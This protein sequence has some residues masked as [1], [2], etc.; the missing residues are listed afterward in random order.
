MQRADYRKLAPEGLRA[1][2]QLETYI[3]NSSIEHSLLELVK[4]RVSQING[5]AYCLDMHTT[6]ARKAGETEQRLYVLSAFREA[7]FFTDREKAALTWAEILTTIADKHPS[8]EDY[9]AVSKHFSDKEIVDL[10]FIIV[11]INGWN[12][13][14]IGFGIKPPAY[15][16]GEA[17]PAD[18]DR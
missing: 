9:A 17:S 4:T 8:D 18:G 13:M 16:D 5:C 3:Q 12:R 11:A 2:V 15:P 6:D 14:A 10:S 7:P 1:M